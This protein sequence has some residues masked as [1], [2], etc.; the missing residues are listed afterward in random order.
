MLQV[1]GA[2]GLLPSADLPLPAEAPFAAPEAGGKAG[3]GWKL[4][5]EGD[6]AF[7]EGTA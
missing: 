7:L 2:E 3:N 6:A 4:T 5:Q 1:Q